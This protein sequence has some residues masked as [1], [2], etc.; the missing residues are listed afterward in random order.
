MENNYARKML[1]DELNKIMLLDPVMYPYGNANIIADYIISR[2]RKIVEK[3]ELREKIIVD[4]VYEA[5]HACR[6]HQSYQSNPDYHVSRAEKALES[7]L[8]LPPTC[9]T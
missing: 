9:R 6:S 3:I 8:E 1:V 4:L 2:E 5:F 7:I